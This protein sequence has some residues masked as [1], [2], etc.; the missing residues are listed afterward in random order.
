MTFISKMNKPLFVFILLAFVSLFLPVGGM[1]NELIYWPDLNSSVSLFGLSIVLSAIVL[2]SRS[3]GFWISLLVLAATFAGAIA[4]IDVISIEGNH[5][6]NAVGLWVFV[7]GLGFLAWRAMALTSLHADKSLIVKILVPTFFGLWI[8]YLWQIATTGFGIPTVLLPSPGLIGI[9]IAA[10][11]DTL[12]GDFQQTF[13]KSVLSGYALGCGSGFIVAI[14]VDKI[15]FLQRGLLPLG[16]LVS[17]IPIV[18][19]APIM[20]MWFGF[21]WQSKA[22]V[23]VIMTFFPMLV[24]T[25]AGLEATSHLE[26]D[27]MRS[28]A[29]SY[30]Q[31]L[32][33]VRLPNALPFIFNALK[34]NSTLALIGAIVAEFFGTPIVG[35]GFRISTEVGRMNVD[36]VWATIAVAA[37]AGSLSY[38]ILA[39]LERSLTFWHPSYRGND[40]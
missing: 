5:R 21:D 18:G 40:R 29:A 1:E 32:I 3:N 34:I 22:A 31:T 36:I 9:A 13:V 17:A 25:L 4:V 26:K 23:I 20:V 12:I 7:V 15:P 37:L 38:G 28:Y 14:L 39:L 27:L 2:L 16:S 35:M 19:I 10:N 33:F 8:L 11:T 24:N 6:F 30:F